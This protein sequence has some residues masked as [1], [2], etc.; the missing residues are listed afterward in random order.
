VPG[1]EGKQPEVI[2]VAVAA[3]LLQMQAI[4]QAPAS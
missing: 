4:T 1:I 2:A 3:Q